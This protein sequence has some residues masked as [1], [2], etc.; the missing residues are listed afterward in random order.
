MNAMSGTINTRIKIR[1]P[2]LLLTLAVSVIGLNSFFGF[3]QSE[4]LG[5]VIRA[6]CYLLICLAWVLYRFRV[7]W[8]N[9]RFCVVLLSFTALY[10]IKYIFFSSHNQTSDFTNFLANL[11]FCLLIDIYIQNRLNTFLRT[12]IFVYSILISVNFFVVPGSG[13]S[14][15][16]TLQDSLSSATTTG[17]G[18]ESYLIVG[19]RN[20]I[21]SNLM[22]KWLLCLYLHI[23]EKHKLLFVLCLLFATANIIF[24]WSATSLVAIMLLLLYVLLENRIKKVPFGILSVIAITFSI[25]IVF[26]RIQ[27]LFAFIIEGILHKSLTFT[28]R[29]YI[30]DTYI[31]LIKQSFSSLLFGVKDMGYAFIPY[32]RRAYH[33]HNMILYLVATTGIAGLTVMA[34]LWVLAYKRMKLYL[35]EKAIK[36]TAIF[37]II[38]LVIGTTEI[39]IY[40]ALPLLCFGYYAPLIIGR[41]MPSK[42]TPV[43]GGEI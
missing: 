29:V 33:P 35:S 14:L 9:S 5:N 8:G 10:M 26:F 42:T 16:E 28:G 24:A 17:F 22:T 32:M 6:S 4:M 12:V 21:F 3:I 38:Y 37:L 30:W 23:G 27:Y 25:S 20:N 11:A 31:D 36:F 40:F 13:V 15:T 18:R 34:S 41:N 2:D 1:K 7:G 39:F 43:K 19:H